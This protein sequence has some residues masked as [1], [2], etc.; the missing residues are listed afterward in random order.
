MKIIIQMI[1]T[2]EKKKMHALFRD[3]ERKPQGM[4]NIAKALFI[5]RAW[6]TL[7]RPPIEACFPKQHGRLVFAAL[8]IFHG[9]MMMTLNLLSKKTNYFLLKISK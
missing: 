1:I 9:L 3:A 2:R 4:I 5:P 7:A 8:L 6:Y